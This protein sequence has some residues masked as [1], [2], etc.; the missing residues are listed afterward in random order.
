MKQYKAVFKYSIL[1]AK[2]AIEQTGE[3]VLIVEA[4]NIAEACENA[5]R[6][7][8][9]FL[10]LK[11]SKFGYVYSYKGFSFVHI[12]IANKL[13]IDSELIKIEKV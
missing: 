10:A 11:Y 3:A 4:E 8:A 2:E 6:N 9:N 7:Y 1:V 13:D 5:C 12:H